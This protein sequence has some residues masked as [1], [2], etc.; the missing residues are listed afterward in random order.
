MSPEE[1]E[2]A[3][4]LRYASNDALPF[5]EKSVKDGYQTFH[6]RDIAGYDE[7]S[8]VLDR[9]TL[10]RY[11]SKA[12]E[13][14]YGKP[15]ADQLTHEEIKDLFPGLEGHIFVSLGLA[16]GLLMEMCHKGWRLETDNE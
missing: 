14:R 7:D 11:V 8:S 9:N 5:V 15:L 13:A 16:N 6:C 12:Y 10:Y 2:L 1:T 4:L 3:D